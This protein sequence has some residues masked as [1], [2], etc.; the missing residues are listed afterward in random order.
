MIQPLFHGA[1]SGGGVFD[2]LEKI[3]YIPYIK[4]LRSE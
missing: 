3:K 4:G 1:Y 2:G